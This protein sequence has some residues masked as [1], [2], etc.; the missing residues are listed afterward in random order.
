[1]EKGTR[2]RF[3]TILYPGGSVKYNYYAETAKGAWRDA[4][5]LVFG[6][7][8]LYDVEKFDNALFEREDLKWMRHTYV[9]HIMMNWDKFYYDYQDGKHHLDEFVNRG[10]KLYGGD[11]VISIWP[12]WPTLGLDP[13]NQFDLFRDL[14]GGT[15]QLRNLSDK[16][17]SQGVKFFVCYNPWDEST[18][19]E[20]H[21]SGIS[22]LIA[23]TAA[24]GVVLDTKG[25][26]SKELQEAADKVRKGVIMYSEGMAVPKD[27]SG[28]PSGRV[29]NALYYAP[30]LNLN[31]L[32]KP[33]FA[34]YRVAE[35]FKEPIQREFATSFFNGYGT[36][37]NI[38][39][40]GQPD[41]V[42]EQYKY[43]GRT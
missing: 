13:R 12:T 6:D 9:M 22:D 40:P 19:S 34:I 31:K 36:E 5:A 1:M 15:K 20:N 24:D 37:I 43:F 7:R 41:W 27:M 10:K 16:L 38:M 14:P 42:E 39:A 25:E 29:H 4:L 28:I 2:T 21:F 8:M 32:I 18:R 26:S 23:E 30:M 35:L 3:E 33:E 17:H 11:D